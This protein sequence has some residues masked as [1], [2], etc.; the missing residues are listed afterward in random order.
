MKSGNGKE[1]QD[2]FL[3]FTKRTDYSKSEGECTQH[4]PP[5]RRIRRVKSW[6]LAVSLLK[7]TVRHSK[8]GLA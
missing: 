3:V 1:A 4:N 8:K 6:N 7:M 5:E 2:R